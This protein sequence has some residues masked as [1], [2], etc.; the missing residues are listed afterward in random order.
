[1]HAPSRFQLLHGPYTAPALRR[2][3]ETKGYFRGGTVV[4]TG[5]S[6]GPIPW[7]R[8]HR[9]GT[10]GGGSGLLVDAELARGV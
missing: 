9:P 3:D 2:G 4:V 1:M 8:C 10:H 6:D 7:P 5:W